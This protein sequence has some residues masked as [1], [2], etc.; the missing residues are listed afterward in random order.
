MSAS[1]VQSFHVAITLRERWRSEEGNNL[2][3]GMRRTGSALTRRTK[4]E[5]LRAVMTTSSDSSSSSFSSSSSSSSETPPLSIK[6]S[7]E[8]VRKKVHARVARAKAKAMELAKTKRTRGNDA[9]DEEKEDEEERN[10][11]KTASSKR[12]LAAETLQK[13]LDLLAAKGEEEDLDARRKRSAAAAVADE[14]F[15]PSRSDSFSGD[16]STFERAA[17]S[18]NEEAQKVLV[19]ALEAK[20]AEREENVNALERKVEEMEM[21]FRKAS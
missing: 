3:P 21:E 5:I 2:L 12:V 20:L 18:E 17:E 11:V 4:K 19:E 16:D 14:E 1:F 15:A 9:Q 7:E 6:N 8:E 13:S 10:A